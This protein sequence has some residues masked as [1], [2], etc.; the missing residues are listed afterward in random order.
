M[1]LALR[2]TTF[3]RLQRVRLESG[4]LCQESPY[5]FVAC[6]LLRYCLLISVAAFYA[7][8]STPEAEPAILIATFANTR[9]RFHWLPPVALPIPLGTGLMTRG[10][11]TIS[12]LG[13]AGNSK[14]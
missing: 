4:M 5:L 9:R 12:L 10:G 2:Y 3:W 6:R 7:D 1:T 13:A 8:I 14:G 11:V